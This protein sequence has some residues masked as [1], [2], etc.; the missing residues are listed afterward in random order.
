MLRGIA[1]ALLTAATLSLW[2]QPPTWSVAGV[3]LTEA[4][5]PARKVTVSLIPMHEGNVRLTAQTASDGTFALEG[6]QKG[7]YQLEVTRSGNP[8][9][10]IRLM[11][12]NS[13]LR[14]IEVSGNVDKLSVTVASEA[15]ISGRVIDADGDPIRNVEVMALQAINYHGRTQH[16]PVGHAQTDDRGQYRIFGLNEGDYV[17]KAVQGMPQDAFVALGA[18]NESPTFDPTFYP[19]ARDLTEAAVVSTCPG[20]ELTADISLRP[21]SGF[22]ISGNVALPDAERE[23]THL[24]L[25]S[26]DGI[27]MPR[28]A[29]LDSDGNFAIDGISPGKYLLSAL[30]FPLHSEAAT[31]GDERINLPVT[32]T[33]TDVTG[34]VL[35]P[36]KGVN[37]RG[38]IRAPGLGPQPDLS[39]LYVVISSKSQSALEGDSKMAPVTLEGTFDLRNVAHA[40][41][42][43]QLFANVERGGK[44]PF[45]AYYLRSASFNGSEALATGFEITTESG[46]SVLE[47]VIAPGANVRGVLTDRTGKLVTGGQVF[48]MPLGRLKGRADLEFQAISDSTGEYEINGVAPGNYVIAAYSMPGNIAALQQNLS[49]PVMDADDS[50]GTQIV[51]GTADISRSLTV[52]ERAVDS[53][54]RNCTGN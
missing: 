53:T 29:P 20:E 10:I 15:A 34:I 4:Q 11:R 6:V 45:A 32:V 16:V 7:N 18:K 21:A 23:R 13:E 3:V 36:A 30:T 25:V 37:V 48:M 40:T 47:L 52:I 31:E 43:L 35:E 28:T 54:R 22:H 39:G 19:S 51:V 2:G 41:Y 44:R 8:V 46:S 5:G 50:S 49:L 38:R 33:Q 17:L 26:A 24:L 14:V 42:R 27:G 9:L 1:M 12:G